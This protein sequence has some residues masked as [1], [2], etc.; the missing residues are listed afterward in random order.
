MTKRLSATPAPGSLEGYAACFHDLFASLAQR[1][2]FCRYLE[3]LLLPVERNKTLTAL[4]NTEPMVDAQRKK[5]QG[6]PWFLSE[7][8]W[9]AAET[10]ARRLELLGADPTTA[11]GDE[12]VLVIDEHGDRKWGKK[13]AHAG[14]QYLA[15]LGKVDSGGVSVSSMWADEGVYYPLEVELYTPAHHFEKGKADPGFRTK[16]K[17]AHQ[18]VEVVGCGG[19]ALQDGGGRLLL[20]GRRGFRAGLERAWD[21]I[22][23]R[24]EGVA[25][26][27]APGGDDRRAVG[28]SRGSRMEERRRSGGWTK[29]VCTFRDGYQEEWW[30]LEVEAG[31]YSPRRRAGHSS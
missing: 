15:N 20:R 7:S 14:K 8:T 2:A 3:G 19:R 11:P 25:R 21:G 26:V 1:Q 18:L 6:L 5:A 4:A 29:V 24:F 28:G 16:L 30:A 27:V 23:A 10:N 13:T 17:I 22:R 31:P 9:Q 12:G